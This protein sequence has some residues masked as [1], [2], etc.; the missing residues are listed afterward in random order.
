MESVISSTLS[1]CEICGG[2]VIVF[3]YKLLWK[4]MWYFFAL[5]KTAAACTPEFMRRQHKRTSERRQSITDECCVWEGAYSGPCWFI[6]W[7]W[8]PRFHNMPET[9]SVTWSKIQTYNKVPASPSWKS[10][11]KG[12]EGNK[13]QDGKRNQS[14][15]EHFCPSWCR[16]FR[17]CFAFNEALLC[18]DIENLSKFVTLL[19]AWGS[20]SLQW[21]Y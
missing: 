1:N 14:K 5:A 20:R 19:T 12:W 11:A 15:V 7:I 10:E 16:Y 17:L 8:R 4:Q 6:W 2:S 13:S 3:I 9:S 21:L 18:T